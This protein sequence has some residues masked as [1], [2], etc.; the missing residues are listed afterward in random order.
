MKH[1]KKCLILAVA[2]LPLLNSCSDSWLEPKPLSIYT[3]ENTYVDADGLYAALVACERNMR[4][5]F[6]ETVLRSQPICIRQT[7]LSQ[8]RPINQVL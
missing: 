3:P 5:E 4:H 2:G 8:V 1:I 6:S 7:W